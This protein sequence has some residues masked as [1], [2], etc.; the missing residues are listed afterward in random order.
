[1]SWSENQ[2][3]VRTNAD[4]VR[5]NRRGKTYSGMQ[6]RSQPNDGLS[7]D[8]NESGAHRG[9]GIEQYSWWHGDIS[10]GTAERRLAMYGQ[11]DG[12]F[13]VRARG[14]DHVL[15]VCHKNSTCNYLIKSK[16][17]GF[18]IGQDAPLF[19]SLPELVDYFRNERGGLVTL[20]DME[21]PVPSNPDTGKYSTIGGADEATSGASQFAQISLDPKGKK[22]KKLI[23]TAAQRRERKE[24][25]KKLY[26]Q[27]LQEQLASLPAYRPFW[28]YGTALVMAIVLVVQISEGGIAE[29]NLGQPGV[30]KLLYKNM[31]GEPDTYSVIPQS[32]VMIGPP[33]RKLIGFGAKFAPC[34]REDIPFKVKFANS[35]EQEQ[36]LQVGCCRKSLGGSAAVCGQ[37]TANDCGNDIEPGLCP[38]TCEGNLYVKPCCFYDGRCEITTADFCESTGGV[39]SESG[40]TCAT[41][42]CLSSLCG[43]GE[44]TNEVADQWY[45]FFTAIFAHAGVL[46]F[47]GNMMLQLSLGVQIERVAG[48]LRTALIYMMAGVGGYLTSCVFSPDV[49]SVGASGSIFGFLG[50]AVVDLLQSWKIVQDP[51]KRLFWTLVEISMYLFV[52]TLPFVDNWAHIG[53]F[54][55]GVLGAII[56]LPYLTFGLMD[57][58][59]KRC[60]MLIAIP[61]VVVLFFI[62][63]LIFYNIQSLNNFCPNCKYIQCYPF[64]EDFC[65]D[66]PGWD[67]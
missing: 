44:V 46:H 43:M 19:Y 62:F 13:L 50:I 57:S 36:N 34:M 56:F 55:F 66:V 54:V 27:Q 10:G 51:C 49:P 52:G 12:L 15:S 29:I 41:A 2:P 40:Q 16:H 38:I 8:G 18:S 25:K 22:K 17:G 9:V 47:L 23:M 61:V 31:S 48:T 59:K 33:S 42:T 32:N 45:R 64:T 7:G 58:I 3:L 63:F 21:C 39:V 28:C 4:K 14:A 11:I 35:L 20:L 5:N 60:L 26:E 53:G 1:M 30:T 67:N 6:F 24:L 37:A 65:K